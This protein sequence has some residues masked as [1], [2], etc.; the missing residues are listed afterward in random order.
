MPD[1]KFLYNVV[2]V[3]KDVLLER[4]WYDKKIEE[5]SLDELSILKDIEGVLPK[6]V[7]FTVDYE[8][9]D[10]D[11]DEDDELLLDPVKSES[12]LADYIRDEEV[13]I[14]ENGVSHQGEYTTLFGRCFVRNDERLA[15]RVLG[16]CVRRDKHNIIDSLTDSNMPLP[17]LYEELFC[18]DGVGN[19]WRYASS[20]TYKELFEDDNVPAGLNVNVPA[21]IE[22]LFYLDAD[23][24]LWSNIE[25]FPEWHSWKE[26]SPQQYEKMRRAAEKHLVR[27]EEKKTSKKRRSRKP[28]TNKDNNGDNS[29]D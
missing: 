7:F 19:D 27:D 15:V 4:E 14:T 26:I 24:G 10:S 11:D 21:D 17:F 23:G 20:A 22:E 12:E 3:L 28:K 9:E 18:V 16:E 13:Y 2:S 25:E 29:K 5:L 1:D 8:V 6:N